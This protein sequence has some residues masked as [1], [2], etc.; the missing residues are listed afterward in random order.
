MLDKEFKVVFIKIL[1]E[2]QKRV[3]DLTETFNKQIENIKKYTELKNSVSEI[4]N[5]L[6]GIS[7]RFDNA[8]HQ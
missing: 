7:S 2:R 3:D 5:T 1:T 8:E 6:E 4:K